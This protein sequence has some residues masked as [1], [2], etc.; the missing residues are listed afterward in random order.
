MMDKH[1][2]LQRNN[3]WLNEI[4]QIAEKHSATFSF[5]GECLK[6]GIDGKNSA[7]LHNVSLY[8]ALMFVRGFDAHSNFESVFDDSK[9]YQ[10]RDES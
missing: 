4:E 5:E 1:D 3:A 9:D 2:V 7:T 6:F 8:S 10:Q